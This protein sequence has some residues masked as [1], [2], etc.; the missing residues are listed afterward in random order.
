M[1]SYKQKLKENCLFVQ[2][3]LTIVYLFDSKNPSGLRLLL[4][5]IVCVL[6]AGLLLLSISWD[7]VDCFP[8]SSS[9]E[10]WGFWIYPKENCLRIWPLLL[11]FLSGF[12]GCYEK[13]SMNWVEIKQLDH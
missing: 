4:K 3:N 9:V 11:P 1:G 13:V 12:L 7:R 5:H 10:S 6:F 8:F 2:L